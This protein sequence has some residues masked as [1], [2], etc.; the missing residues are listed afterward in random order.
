MVK[1]LNKIMIKQLNGMKRRQN[2]GYLDAQYN[3]AI[4]Y[5]NGLGVGKAPEKAFQWYRKAAE[6][7]R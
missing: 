7:G 1:A 3:L 2:K 4:M 6:Q 5:D